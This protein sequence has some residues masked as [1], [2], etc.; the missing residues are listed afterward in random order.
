MLLRLSQIVGQL[1]LAFI[2]LEDSLYFITFFISTFLVKL[3]D[4]FF[5]FPELKSFIEADHKISVLVGKQNSLSVGN[6]FGI[7]ED[8]IVISLPH[9]YVHRS[10][11]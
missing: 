1:F 9:V 11:F 2:A 3:F 7:A 10:R 4:R 8:A 6:T 5:I